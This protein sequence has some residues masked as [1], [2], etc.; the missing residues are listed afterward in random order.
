MASMEMSGISQVR[1]ISVV[2]I[3]VSIP[4]TWYIHT[5]MY[6]KENIHHTIS[7]LQIIYI[8]IYIFKNRRER[9]QFLPSYICIH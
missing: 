1:K 3:K 6:F 4:F 9:K 2:K 5:H 7:R 8:Y